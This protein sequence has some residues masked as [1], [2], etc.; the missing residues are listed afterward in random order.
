[1][2]EPRIVVRRDGPYRIEGDVPVL[3]AAIVET[4]R[5]EPVAWDDG[6]TFE[7]PE[8]DVYELCRCGRSSTKP[9]CDSTHEQIPFDGTETADRGPI[10]ARRETW[11]GEADLVLYDDLSL[12]SKAGFCRTVSTGVWEML[13]EAGD[14]VVREELIAM[15]GRCP[16]GRLAHAVRPDLEPVEE[17]YDASIGVEPNGPYRLRG[18][19]AVVSEDGTPYEVRNRQALCRCGQSD[20]KPFC[21]GSH[22]IVGFRD[23]AMPG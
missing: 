14:P 16:S 20:N 13:D 10:S 17:R 6:P 9:F 1:M 21:D 2:T 18:N 23:P 12:C 4:D 8:E 7:R 15:V 11:E 19:I 3:R 5:G 22:K